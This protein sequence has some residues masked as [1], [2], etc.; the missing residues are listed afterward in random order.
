MNLK[1]VFA[2]LLCL[3]I[4][5]A[6]SAKANELSQI[7]QQMNAMKA[8]Y[9]AQIK[10][11]LERVEVLE[12]KQT[13]E[14]AKINEK[15]DKSLIDIDYV[16]RYEG[17]FKKG[18][19]VIDNPAGFGKI[20][21]GGYADIEF[22]NFQNRD[23]N[24]DQH[25]WI[26]NLGAELGERLRF[27]SEYEIEHGGPDASGGGEAKVEQAWIDYLISDW[28][29]FRAGALLVPFGRY[30]LYH[31][32]DLQDLTDRP[33]VARRVIPTTWTESG[34]GFH[35]GFNPKL[36]EYEDLSLDYEVYVFNGL[37]DGF[38][39]T[40]F[41]SATGSLGGDNNNS[42][43][44]AARLAIS[45][46]LGHESGL[47]G[48]HGKYNKLDDRISGAAFDWL[49]TFGP[50]ELVGEYAYFD[51]DQPPATDIAETLKGY[52]IQ[53]NYHFW[54][55]FLDNTFLKEGFDD[56]QL[57][58]VS[59]YGWVKIEDDSDAGVGDNEESRFTLGLNYRPVPSWVFKLEYQWNRTENESL[60]RGDNDGFMASVAMGF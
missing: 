22:E 55:E 37:D 21:L 40:G 53:A 59:R 18:G 51:V 38:S 23:S 24:F 44:V 29:N 56:P 20:S 60:E 11:L 17:P 49:S 13:K 28:I 58:L 35:G 30:N 27:Y 14:V 8:D 36:G 52:Y 39:D 10:R 25:R 7:K 45:P 43:S 41:R 54:P 3:L 50:L 33:L 57:T 46:F 47:S 12:E 19:L 9:E 4:F 34:V 6:S 5:V 31:D 42:K 32:S 48:Y 26:I 15:I 1:K 2:S 16:G